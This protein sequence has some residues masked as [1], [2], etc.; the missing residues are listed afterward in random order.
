MAITYLI[1]GMA[2]Q[3]MRGVLHKA[4]HRILFDVAVLFVFYYIT[5]F[6]IENTT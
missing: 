6:F 3:L 2:R 1:L 4:S 5:K